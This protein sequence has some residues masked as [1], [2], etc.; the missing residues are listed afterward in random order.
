MNSKKLFIGI[1]IFWLVL[2]VGFIASKELVLRSGE[3]IT[4][5][6]VPVD[7]RDLFR[8]DYVVLRY[9]ISNLNSTVTNG[10]NFTPG[11]TVYVQ[12][13]ADGN[14]SVPVGISRQKPEGLFIKGTV[15]EPS[16]WGNG[17]QVA[18]GIES[19]F[20]PENKGWI[21]ERNQGTALT[22]K[23]RVDK[24]GNAVIKEALI[25]GAPINYNQDRPY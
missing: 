21:L 17:V 10:Q 19:Y 18:Y 25:D 20:V 15:Q 14:F 8:G 22:V 16:W 4:L 11:E 3:E 1:G 6:T 2:L 5:R 12:L 24:N 23:A 9:D 7:P 13:A